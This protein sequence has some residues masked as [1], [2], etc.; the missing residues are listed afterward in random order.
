MIETRMPA[1]GSD[2]DAGTLNEC[3]IKPG[4]TVRRG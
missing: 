4:D 1:L 3:L 2:M